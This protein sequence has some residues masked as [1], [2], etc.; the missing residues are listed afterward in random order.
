MG[1]EEAHMHFSEWAQNHWHMKS[2][3]PTLTSTAKNRKKKQSASYL[4]NHD[5]LLCQFSWRCL[6][7]VNQE[8]KW[9]LLFGKCHK[10]PEYTNWS[11]ML[12]M[13]KLWIY[14]KHQQ[15]TSASRERLKN[16]SMIKKERLVFL[17]SNNDSQCFCKLG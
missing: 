9:F 5:I 6:K 12:L 4:E 14:F 1:G 7:D 11:L 15:K 17:W 13:E 2:T 3:L 10:W 16:T 8:S